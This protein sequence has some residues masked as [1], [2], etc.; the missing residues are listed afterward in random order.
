[1]KL[2]VLVYSNNDYYQKKNH[3]IL[4]INLECST[5]NPDASFMDCNEVE[6]LQD[7]HYPTK[8][9]HHFLT[10]FTYCLINMNWL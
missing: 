10:H 6:S 9:N 4:H 7:H 8:Y 3:Q 2:P 1:M 5:S